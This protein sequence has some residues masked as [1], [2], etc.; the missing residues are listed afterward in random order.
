MLY[1]GLKKRNLPQHTKPKIIFVLQGLFAC[2]PYG[3]IALK[4]TLINNFPDID[5]RCDIFVPQYVYKWM[6][7]EEGEGDQTQWTRHKHGA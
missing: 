6:I 2:F 1:L 4:N 3:W 5:D 7:F